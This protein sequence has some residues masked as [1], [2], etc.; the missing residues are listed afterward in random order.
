MI[1]ALTKVVN[2][3][4]GGGIER[5]YYGELFSKR[6]HWQGNLYSQSVSRGCIQRCDEKM[7]GRIH[8][9]C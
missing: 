3:E 5:V 2:R 1:G 7:R 9:V 4:G 6:V 8:K